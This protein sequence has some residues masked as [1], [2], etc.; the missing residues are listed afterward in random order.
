MSRA[1]LCGSERKIRPAGTADGP[2]RLVLHACCTQHG[3]QLEPGVELPDCEPDRGTVGAAA[4]PPPRVQ[5]SLA[6]RQ[7]R[8]P[9]KIASTTCCGTWWAILGLNQWPLPCQGSALP[10]S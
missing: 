6:E 10:L 2:F 5:C 3:F 8:D 9:P 1:G 7:I 4:S